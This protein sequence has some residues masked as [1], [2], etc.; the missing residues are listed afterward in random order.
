MKHLLALLLL[1]PTAAASAQQDFGKGHWLDLT[2]PFNEHS[3]Y[4]PTAT[5]FTKTTVF[6]GQTEGG[7]FYT[8]YEFHAAEH[9]GTHLDAPIH[10][11]KGGHSNDQIPLTRLTGH[12]A[13]IHLGDK[14]DGDRDYL[15][16]VQDILDWETAHGKLTEGTIVL[17]D[18]GSAKF[19]GDKVRYMGT[20]ERGDAAVAKLHFPGLSAEAAQLL[21][22]RKIGAV[23]LD[24]PSIDFGQSKEFM[25]HQV[26]FEKNIPAFEN[27]AN[28]D[29]LPA[30]GS[31]I[32]A[33]PMK[34]EGG[35]G[36]P[37]R[38][39]AFVAD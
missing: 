10:F 33:L 2:H 7:W 20:D 31:F 26:L 5:P 29:T 4:W 36:G 23:G 30:T 38:I 22:E 19:Y 25:A 24:T 1:L 34:I 21:V 37:L 14:I 35:S 6:E 3:I 17:L 18:T 8:A 32:I 12:G 15:V 13:V 39:V 11:A 27:V 28:L 16:S 9:G